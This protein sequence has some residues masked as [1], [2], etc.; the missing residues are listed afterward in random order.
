MKWNASAHSANETSEYLFR[1]LIP[2]IGNKRKLLGLIERAIEASN[3]TPETHR[4][5]DLFSGTG[6]VG[7]FARHLGYGVLANDWEPY[8]E[9]LNRCYLEISKPPLFFGKRSYDDVLNELN[10]LPDREDWVTKHLCPRHDEAFDITKDRLF[11][12]R[13]NGRRIDAIRYKIAGWEKEGKLSS[14]QQAALLAPL[15]YQC[16]YNANTSGVFKGFHNGWGGKTET[17]LYRIKGELKLRPAL[18]LDNGKE[19]Q[20]IRSDAQE[21]APN[22]KAKS[23]VYLDPPYNQ[24]PYGSNY[25]VLNSVTL[26]DKPELSQQISGHGD[27]AA[28]RTDWRTERRSAYNYAAKAAAAYKKLLKSLKAEW[29]ATSYSTDGMIPLRCLIEANLEVGDVQI[30][31]QPYKRYR[32]STQRYSQKPMNIE[33]IVLTKTGSQATQTVDSLTAKIREHEKSILEEF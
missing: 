4:F 18:F 6:V 23:F 21:L 25:H 2:Y 12:M 31:T 29:I 28:I 5:V 19:S 33:F 3:I 11:Y 22:I 15:L 1:H 9:I 32:V 7:R 16:C 26:W 14:H 13:K 24:H 20:V 30:F 8:S 27:K 17:A 10:A